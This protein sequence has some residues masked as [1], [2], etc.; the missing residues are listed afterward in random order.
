MKT[1]MFFCLHY[2][3]IIR[4]IIKMISVN[5]MNMFIGKKLTA[6]FLFCNYSMNSFSSFLTKVVR[7]L[8]F[9]DFFKRYYRF[10]II[11]I[12]TE[13]SCA[14]KRAA[15]LLGLFYWKGKGVFTPRTSFIKP[16]IHRDYNI[17]CSFKLSTKE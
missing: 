8:L 10:F 7:L 4:R 14:T 9:S 1:S 12:I 3:K 2:L 13:F 11:S 16:I 6:N 17:V 5:M 15:Y